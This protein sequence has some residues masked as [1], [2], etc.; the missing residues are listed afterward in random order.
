VLSVI[1]PIF[2]ENGDV[3]SQDL[4]DTALDSLYDTQFA[5]EAD[6]DAIG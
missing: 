3:A 2:V 4:I 6:P 1:G 5:E